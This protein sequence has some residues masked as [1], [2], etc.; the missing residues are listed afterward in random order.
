MLS[1]DRASVRGIS[2]GKS[3]KKNMRGT[4]GLVGDLVRRTAVL[5]RGLVSPVKD[6]RAMKIKELGRG[7][8][9]PQK[10]HKYQENGE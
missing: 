6:S 2:P 3:G 10:G 7:A 5:E 9:G 1:I 4:I 8:A